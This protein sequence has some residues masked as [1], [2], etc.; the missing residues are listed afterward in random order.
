MF[1]VLFKTLNTKF[2]KAIINRQTKSNEI[3][4]EDEK[5]SILIPKNYQIINLVENKNQ[6]S[7]EE[8]SEP[9]K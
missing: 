7:S 4:L 1:G 3:F 6:F 5:A 9:I 2:S 8:F